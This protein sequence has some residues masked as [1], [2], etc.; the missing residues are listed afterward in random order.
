VLNDTV[1]A[2]LTSRVGTMSSRTRLV[3]KRY[4]I[5][6]PEDQRHALG[7]PKPI[8]PSGGPAG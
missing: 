1:T 5:T 3:F 7:R 4:D 2:S 6:S 8:A